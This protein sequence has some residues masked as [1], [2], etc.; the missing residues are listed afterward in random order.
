MLLVSLYKGSAYDNSVAVDPA[1]QQEYVSHLL[2]WTAIEE[3]LRRGAQSY[4]LGPKAE[5]SSFM[6][7]PSEKSRGIS[8]L[9]EGWA[10]DS[11]R[12]VGV[13][14]EFLSARLL[15]AVMNAQADSLQEYFGVRG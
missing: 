2:K 14:E 1:F 7:L 6:A 3:L 11:V 9:K 8:Y 4:E 15:Q 12:R 10:R 5:S 13:A